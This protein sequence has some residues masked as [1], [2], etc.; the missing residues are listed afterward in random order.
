MMHPWMVGCFRDINHGTCLRHLT[1]YNLPR[2]FLHHIYDLLI[3]TPCAMR[4][5]VQ[6]LRSGSQRDIKKLVW[7]DILVTFR[8]KVLDLLLNLK[9]P[10]L[11][12]FNNQQSTISC[13][14]TS[15]IVDLPTESTETL[16]NHLA[17]WVRIRTDTFIRSLIV[18]PSNL[19]SGQMIDDQLIFQSNIGCN[20]KSYLCVTT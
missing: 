4:D 15:F 6:Y 16:E 12:F 3:L 1:F 7:N 10:V 13:V 14:S 19:R 8:R 20:N 2:F 11:S 18:K 5:D 17:I 9:L